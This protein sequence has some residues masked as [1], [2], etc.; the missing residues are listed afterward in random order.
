MIEGILVRGE[1][2]YVYDWDKGCRVPKQCE[3]SGCRGED[4]T[5]IT[6]IAALMNL[7]K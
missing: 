4:V 6:N 2:D 3:N 7:A 5:R 1:A